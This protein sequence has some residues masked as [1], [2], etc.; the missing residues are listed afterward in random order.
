MPSARSR[1]QS[2]LDIIHRMYVGSSLW[3][4]MA[5]SS[6]QGS[7]QVAVPFNLQ[8]KKPPVVAE[9]DNWP[10]GDGYPR[11]VRCHQC[12]GWSEWRYVCEKGA[13]EGLPLEDGLECWRCY[14]QRKGDNV[15]WGG[16][17]E[18]VRSAVF[19]RPRTS[20]GRVATPVVLYI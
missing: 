13:L 6:S 11:M 4:S 20:C 5:S 2:Y 7:N 14:M 16:S 15:T 1:K 12:N 9:G 19:H 18:I 10:A 17:Q 3:V 8:R